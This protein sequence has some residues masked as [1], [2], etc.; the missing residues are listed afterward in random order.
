MARNSKAKPMAGRVRLVTTIA[1]NL[2]VEE[3]EA[4]CREWAVRHFGGKTVGS[5][6][7]DA[8]AVREA[9]VTFS[10]QDYSDDSP[11]LRGA[12]VTV[13]NQI[14]ADTPSS[15]EVPA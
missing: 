4:A 10:M 7:V 15:D 3:V 1:I 11:D 12:T 9:E 6:I 13:R 2:T 14:V 5:T 8:Q